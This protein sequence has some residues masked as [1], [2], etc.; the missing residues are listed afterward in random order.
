[1]QPE[2]EVSPVVVISDGE[3]LLENLKAC[4]KNEV[5]LRKALKDGNFPPV[6]KIYTAFVD[7]DELS[8]Y[9]MNEEENNNDI[10]S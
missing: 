4:G 8:V 5:W 3:I 2:K 1:M 9:E 7:K 10:Y 6:G